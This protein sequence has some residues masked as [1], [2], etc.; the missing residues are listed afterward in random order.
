MYVSFLLVAFPSLQRWSCL[1]LAVCREEQIM[2][3]GRTF[4]IS[5]EIFAFIFCLHPSAWVS[6]VLTA[7]VLMLTSNQEPLPYSTM[8]VFLTLIAIALCQGQTQIIH[9]P[10]LW[11]MKNEQI[12][13][14]KWPIRTL[15]L[16][17][18]PIRT[19]WLFEVADQSPVLSAKSSHSP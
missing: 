5:V 12:C 13:L 2:E 17:E 19:L 1:L 11:I 15:Y 16:F 3:P 6:P 7:L 8:W 4:R 18:W 9:S 10:I 14:L